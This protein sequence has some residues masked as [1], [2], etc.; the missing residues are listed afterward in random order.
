MNDS[1]SL[2][3]D[4]YRGLHGGLC[5]KVDNI[6]GR[7]ANTALGAGSAEGGQ[8]VGAVDIDKAAFGVG[9]SGVEAVEAEDAG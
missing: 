4:G 9:I 7:H 8:V 5:E 6:V 1:K 3:G 2:W